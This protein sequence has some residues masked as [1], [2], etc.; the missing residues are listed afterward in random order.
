MNKILSI[1]GKILLGLLAFLLFL[2]L[3]IWFKIYYDNKLNKKGLHRITESFGQALFNLI[4]IIWGLYKGNV[5]V[6]FNFF[7][8]I[9][10]IDTKDFKTINPKDFDLG[11][12][13]S[14]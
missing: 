12:N 5:I 2:F 10:G 13:I 8:S 4:A 6:T 7:L 14:P 9:F 3:V 1:I 11:F